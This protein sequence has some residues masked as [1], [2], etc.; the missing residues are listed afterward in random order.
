MELAEAIAL[1]Q[2]ADFPRDGPALWT[3][4]GCGTGLFTYALA[5]LLLPGSTIYAVDKS[6]VPLSKLPN[7]NQVLIRP[8]QLDFLTQQLPY[9]NLNGILMAN[10]LHYVKDKTAC[11]ARLSQSLTPQGC[12]LL[13]EY[14]TALPN[15]WVPYP[16]RY[17]FLAG[18]FAP[19][20]YTSVTRLQ[21]R[22]SRYGRANL[23]AAL[24]R[25]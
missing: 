13:V 25:R 2:P 17:D 1:L 23:Y 15:P 21:E 8:Q 12:F 19:L 3:D 7:P 9:A 24:I 4:L 6:A 10:S 11:I 5:H 14:D 22:P 20:G 16:I 18:L